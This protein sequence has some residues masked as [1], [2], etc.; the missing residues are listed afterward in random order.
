MLV[1]KHFV[2][3]YFAGIAVVYVFVFLVVLCLFSTLE[4]GFLVF[5]S[6]LHLV[7]FK[8]THLLVLMHFCFLLFGV[9]FTTGEG[10]AGRAASF[11]IWEGGKGR[12]LLHLLLLGRRLG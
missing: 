11:A 7:Q 12:F 6:R 2:E 4:G 8:E 5:F 10:M 3:V 9:E 1:F